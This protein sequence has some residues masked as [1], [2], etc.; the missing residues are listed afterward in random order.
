M[1]GGVVAVCI[2]VGRAIALYSVSKKSWV[3]IPPEAAHFSLKKGKSGLCQVLL[4]C[5]V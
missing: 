4:C 5:V 2:S 3:R 1:F